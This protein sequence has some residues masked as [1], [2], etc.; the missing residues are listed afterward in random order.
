M[1]PRVPTAMIRMFSFGIASLRSFGGCRRG[2]G[3]A[4]GLAAGGR[5]P[6]AGSTEK[7][8]FDGDA[9]PRGGVVGAG[10]FS[11]LDEPKRS[12]RRLWCSTVDEASGAD[13]TEALSSA[14][15]AMKLSASPP[16]SLPLA[17]LREA[18]KGVASSLWW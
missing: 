12:K 13:T 16:P 6:A 5:D 18:P 8:I 10:D 2:V 14:V 7:R 4:S 17:S 3:A 11:A 15:P 1:S 9:L